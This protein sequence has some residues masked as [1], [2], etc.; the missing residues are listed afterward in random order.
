MFGRWPIR[1]RLAAGFSAGLLVVLV[2]AG[3]FVFIQVRHSLNDAIEISLAA[4]AGDARSI[5]E[6]TPSR[7]I[8]LGG[9]PV[10]EE[11]STFTQI[12]SPGGRLIASTFPASEAVVGP[13][14]LREA[15]DRTAYSEPVEVAGL[16]GPFRTEA[17]RVQ[18]PYGK[19]IAVVGVTI[20]DRQE[21]LSLIGKSF[22]IGGPLALLLAS[23]IGYLL[24]ARALAPVEA[25]R[26]RARE[27]TLDRAGDRLPRPAADDELRRL[28]DT[29]NEMLDR[30]EHALQ[31]ERVFV[32]D[33]SHELRTPLAI[34]KSEIE[35]ALRTGGPREDLES[36]LVSANEEVDHLVLLAEDLLVI[37]R[38]EQ[39]R[40][41]LK[42]EP[43]E[44]GALLDRIATRF[45]G[46]LSESGKALSVEATGV[47]IY[48]IDRQRVEQAVSNLVENALRHGGE[49]IS[50]AAK[51]G[52]GRL[53]ITVADDG[54]GFPGGFADQAF[55]RFSQADSGRGGSGTGLGL[56]IVRAIARA[57][58]GDAVIVGDGSPGARVSLTLTARSLSSDRDAPGL[59]LK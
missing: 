58:D 32:S 47:G 15:A 22:A 50:L 16:E 30:V 57:H 42:R 36:A 34:L 24:G 26:S 39:G 44:V 23:M 9:R 28:A 12:L 48:E 8:D 41:P 3:A 21:T 37:A 53:E 52:D 35:L 55:E 54:P 49:K 33:A 29:L 43:V 11:E 7:E 25:M 46:R 38:A 13:G 2:L 20:S 59:A 10:G 5:I 45:E 1:I 27:I 17:F 56:A 40:L 6:G 14:V 51:G 19:R 31:R 4:R 18:G